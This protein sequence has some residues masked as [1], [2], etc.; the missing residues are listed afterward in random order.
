MTLVFN[1]AGIQTITDF[2]N[3]KLGQQLTIINTTANNLTIDRTNAYL[4]GGV[5]SVLGQYDSLRIVYYTRW[6]ALGAV[7]ANS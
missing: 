5:S 1:L 7:S 2:T 6:Y 4:S 3:A